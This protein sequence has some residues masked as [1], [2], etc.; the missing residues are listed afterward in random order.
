MSCASRPEHCCFD[1]LIKHTKSGTSGNIHI[2]IQ[3]RAEKRT[4][5]FFQKFYFHAAL[6]AQSCR[7]LC[8]PTNG[9]PPGSSIRGIL[10][11]RLLE[12]VAVSFS[13]R[14]SRLR[15]RTHISCSTS[16]FFTIWARVDSSLLQFHLNILFLFQ[17][18]SW[19]SPYLSFQRST[20]KPPVLKMRNESRKTTSSYCIA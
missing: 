6:V 8:D 16:G 14:S 1:R 11:A 2:D 13:R 5:A 15:D 3:K 4:K 20:P 18:R 10:Q 19:A 12:C 17:R 9:S 7:S